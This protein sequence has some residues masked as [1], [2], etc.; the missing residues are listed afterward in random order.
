MA[1]ADAKGRTL[2]LVEVRISV[3]IPAYNAGPR[4]KSC[5]DALRRSREDVFEII[6]VDDGSN[7]NTG[8]FAADFGVSV[9][10]SDRH[11]PA[12]ARNLGAKAATGNVLLFLDADVCVHSYTLRKII[13]S[14]E[15]D[16]A[17]D[18]LIGSYDNDPQSP[19]FLSQYRNLMHAY[20][21]QTGRER[22]STFW[23]GCGAIRRDL[24][25]E[26]NGFDE[27]FT[28]PAI[29]D[30]ELGYRLI[31]AGR[32][33]ILDRSLQV[34]HLKRW[35]FWRLVKTDIL[36]RGIP[37]T[38]LILRDRCMPTDLNLQLSQRVS[39]ALVFLLVT[40]AG[41]AGVYWGGYFL[42][43]LFAITFGL[44]TRWWVEFAAPDRPRIAAVL[45]V[46]VV[47]LIVAL[48]YFYRMFGI[49]PPLLVCPL[50][51]LAKHRYA[52]GG[53]RRKLL[54]PFTL[55][56]T[57]GSVFLA[58]C[59]LPAH[60]LVFLCFLIVAILGVINSQFFLFLAG[61]RGVPFMLAALPFH[62]FYHFYNGISF[63][64]GLLCHVCGIA[65]RTPQYPSEPSSPSVRH[66][67]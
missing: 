23:S 65:V 21:H 17:L 58:A 51:L 7:D 41:V 15:S 1:E 35:T 26:H 12:F 55:V 61:T 11:G 59:Y 36:D 9:L 31:R 46:L 25:L 66:L 24:F 34:K 14:F 32:K 22:A 54:L 63:T 45:F 20:V 56:Y 43:P 57:G 27:A 49:I 19:D 67:S 50:L 60:R 42:I 6:V 2:G 62:L 38:E 28:R 18:A 10:A 48:A 64:I 5:L 16:P 53:P 33:I 52:D 8:R 44:L 3:V 13:E 37:W 39:V 40:L 4:L 47:G 29:E 30:I